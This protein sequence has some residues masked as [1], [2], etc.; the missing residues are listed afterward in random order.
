M[1]CCFQRETGPG[2]T[3]SALTISRF[4][5]SSGTFCGAP[6]K[7][8]FDPH[9]T[10]TTEEASPDGRPKMSP[11]RL[12]PRFPGLGIK[13]NQPVIQVPDARGP[14][15]SLSSSDRMELI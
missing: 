14:D 4:G 6:P 1:I 7:Q 12:R 9:D 10:S 5:L 11:T 3:I 8:R 13:M 2:P 15:I